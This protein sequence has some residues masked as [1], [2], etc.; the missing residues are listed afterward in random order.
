MKNVTAISIRE[1]KYIKGIFEKNLGNI[2]IIFD[3]MII[4]KIKLKN[5]MVCAM[6]NTKVSSSSFPF[7]LRKPSGGLPNIMRN[8]GLMTENSFMVNK[9]RNIAPNGP[10][11]FLEMDMIFS[12][13][14]TLFMIIVL[15]GSGTM[16]FMNFSRWTEG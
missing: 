2:F 8:A 4:E 11:S 15:Y 16:F 7:P 5:M 13:L 1:K 14:R 3:W 10:E 12:S 6:E 9:K